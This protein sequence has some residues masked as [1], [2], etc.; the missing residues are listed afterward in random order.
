MKGVRI[1]R[2]VGSQQKR[3]KYWE[4]NKRAV[5]LDGKGLDCTGLLCPFL[6]SLFLLFL[7]VCTMPGLS[8]VDCCH[9][10][11]EVRTLDIV[12][13]FISCARRKFRAWKTLRFILSPFAAKL[14]NKLLFCFSSENENVLQMYRKETFDCLP[15]FVRVF[16]I[17]SNKN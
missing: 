11:N 9:R 15:S 6:P 10:D 3:K 13:S 8:F 4:K 17:D 1:T 5:E 14:L 7:Y 16:P 12:S 2:G